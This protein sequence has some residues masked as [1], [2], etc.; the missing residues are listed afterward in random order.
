MIARF[1]L[2]LLTSGLT[3]QTVAQSR[4]DELIP[5]TAHYERAT[6]AMAGHLPVPLSTL[7]YC[8][9]AGYSK[10]YEATAKV[11]QRY[12]TWERWATLG[13][14]QLSQTPPEGPYNCGANFVSRD[15][16]IGVEVRSRHDIPLQV[17]HEVVSGYLQLASNLPQQVELA[18][19]P[20]HCGGSWS[21]AEHGYQL[22]YSEKPRETL[23]FVL[24]KV[25]S[26]TPCVWE[27][28]QLPTK[29][30]MH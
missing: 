28:T 26:P 23:R 10:R 15:S 27:M 6:Q 17:V 29:I 2:L 8:G 13:C 4:C 1:T 12:E 7:S 16:A 30:S 24:R 9:V 19:V 20:V 21:S 22:S 11:Y 3:W 18:Y 14:W 5:G 25:C